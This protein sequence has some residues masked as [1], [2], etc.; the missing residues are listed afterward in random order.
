MSVRAE[1]SCDG[2]G[3][4]GNFSLNLRDLEGWEEQVGN[5]DNNWLDGNDWSFDSMNNF[6]YCPTCV[7]EMIKSGEL[8]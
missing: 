2:R 4:V 3:C 1:V 5:A 8:K 6:H 7:R